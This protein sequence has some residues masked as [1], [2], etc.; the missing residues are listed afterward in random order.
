LSAARV[1]HQT[2]V[3]AVPN[4]VASQRSYRVTADT[5][6]VY[7]GVEEDVDRGVPVGGFFLFAMHHFAHRS[8]EQDGEPRAA[9]AAAPRC[10]RS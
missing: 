4:Q 7:K 8:V 10:G 5:P 3:T 6:P 1:D 9:S 2:V